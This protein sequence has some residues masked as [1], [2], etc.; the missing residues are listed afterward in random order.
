[1]T[2][3][4]ID[5]AG[6][7]LARTSAGLWRQVG[8]LAVAAAVEGDD[9][10]RL[11]LA[12]GL[13][14]L[15]HPDEAASVAT[16]VDQTAWGIWLGVLAV[17]QN[18]H[19]DRARELASAARE[20]LPDTPDGRE[21]R[22]RLD[23]LDAELDALRGA[24]NPAR[25]DL[26]GYETEA[27]RRALLVGRSSVSYLTDP[28]IG[29]DGLVRFAPYGGATEGNRAHLSLGQIIDGLQR[30]EFGQGRR[31]PTDHSSVLE[32]ALMLTALTEAGAARTDEL[33]Q[34]AEEV[35]L[36][37]EE[38]TRKGEEL[39]D[40][41]ARLIA[42]RARL[43]RAAMPNGGEATP[44]EG[45]IP[46]TPHEATAILGVGP[47]PNR[48]EVETAYK[49]LVRSAHPD[50]VADLHPGIRHEA[51]NLTVALNAAR[52]LLLEHSGQSAVG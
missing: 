22:R 1:V 11:G 31:V 3:S 20:A 36:E 29:G 23:D 52:D 44:S 8:L 27:R 48:A 9:D 51:E 12:R 14:A 21:V 34:L 18:G 33:M 28:S 13:L 17:G 43:K 41:L 19:I 5:A 46:K 37:R 45:F 40:E 25:F 15:D 26:L 7:R 32:P 47:N 38:L 4:F 39:D 6:T 35:R 10:A 30:G 16:S 2:R 42:E 24:D 49:E 50:R